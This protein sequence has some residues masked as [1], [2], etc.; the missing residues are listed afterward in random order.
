[1]YVCMHIWVDLTPIT[2]LDKHLGPMTMVYMSLVFVYNKTDIGSCHTCS[3]G[4]G[5]KT[6]IGPIIF[7]CGQRV[8]VKDNMF[9]ANTI[10]YI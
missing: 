6:S 10:S 2:E 9:Q 7:S 8:D 1:M 5:E 4:R 3:W